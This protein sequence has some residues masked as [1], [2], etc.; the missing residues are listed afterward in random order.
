MSRVELTFKAE[1]YY[2]EPCSLKQGT[3]VTELVR[4][5]PKSVVMFGKLVGDE[6]Y[7]CPICFDPKFNVKGKTKVKDGAR[8]KQK[9]AVAADSEGFGAGSGNDGAK[10]SVLRIVTDN[11]SVEGDAEA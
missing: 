1:Q 6:Y 9:P 2:C 5:I 8:I 11:G 10:A 3:L 7:C 4:M